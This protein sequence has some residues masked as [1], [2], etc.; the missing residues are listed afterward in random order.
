ME[1][2]YNCPKCGVPTTTTKDIVSKK[3]GRAHTLWVCESGCMNGQYPHSFF[4]PWKDKPQAIQTSQPQ[5]PRLPD[6]NHRLLID[7]NTKLDRILL[8]LSDPLEKRFKGTMEPE[9]HGPE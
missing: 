5:A 4:P 7:V 3:S 8:I 2:S 9:L 6:T 1:K